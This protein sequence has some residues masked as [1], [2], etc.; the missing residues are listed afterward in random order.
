MELPKHQ[1]GVVRALER[2]KGKQK[3]D[4]QQEAQG[5]FRQPKKASCIKLS[6]KERTLYTHCLLCGLPTHRHP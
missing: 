1:S 4:I 2:N 5:V 6:A 3:R